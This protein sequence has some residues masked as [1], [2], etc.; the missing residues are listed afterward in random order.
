M[1]SA[2]TAQVSVVNAGIP[3]AGQAVVVIASEGKYE[4]VTDL[5]GRYSIA[6]SGKY[7]RLR[8]NNKPVT[9]IFQVNQG[10][11]QVDISTL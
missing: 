5:N 4:G 11:V 2:G 1:A 3:V 6:I 8:V 9:G 10:T 7:Y